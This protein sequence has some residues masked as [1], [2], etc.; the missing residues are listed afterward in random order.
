M[1]LSDTHEAGTIWAAWRQWARA[2]DRQASRRAGRQAGWQAG[3]LAGY[4]FV[5]VQG[6]AKVGRRR[7]EER[8]GSTRWGNCQDQPSSLGDPRAGEARSAV[9]I[10]GNAHRIASLFVEAQGG[11]PKL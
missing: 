5:F 10:M 7:G 9:G 6:D 11:S 3:W 4:R 2:A 1:A 8:G